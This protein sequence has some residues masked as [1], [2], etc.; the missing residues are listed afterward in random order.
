MPHPFAPFRKSAACRA[1]KLSGV[2]HLICVVTD[3]EEAGILAV[4]HAT[5]W[6]QR[7]LGSLR[8]G[9]AI[10]YALDPEDASS[11]AVPAQ[12]AAHSAV[13]RRKRKRV[14]KIEKVPVKPPAEAATARTGSTLKVCQSPHCELLRHQ[15]VA[16]CRLKFRYFLCHAAGEAGAD[17][18][19][20]V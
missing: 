17:G 8:S 5:S 16:R 7:W 6:P 12:A 9:S 18:S 2:R 19:G 11:L 1:A 13:Q 14:L 20:K 10:S 15:V 3:N 4:N